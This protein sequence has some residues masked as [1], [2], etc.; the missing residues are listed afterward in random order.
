M[1]S[2]F[3]F[4]VILLVFLFASPIHAFIGFERWYGHPVYVNES[5]W[6]VVQTSDGGYI[7]AGAIGDPTG[8]P[9]PSGECVYLLK[10]DS[11]GDSLWAK[12]CGGEF[13]YS[14]AQTTDDG[15]IITGVTRSPATGS[16]DVY[17]VKT[18]SNG[19][20]MW[21]R[22]YGD[23]NIDCGYSVAQTTDGGYIITGRTF[24]YTTNGYYSDVYLIKTDSSGD[25]LWTR[26]HG[27]R[28]HDG[29]FSVAQ[30][31]DKGYIITGYTRHRSSNVYL[32]KT[33]S[34]GNT[35]WTNTYGN[36]GA[37]IHDEGYSVAQTFDGGYII[38]GYSARDTNNS[39][40][41]IYLLK[42]NSIGN[43][44][45]ERRYGG[46]SDD[47]GRSV[48]QTSDGG[49]IITGITHSWV[50]GGG[51]YLIKTDSS[52][53]TLWTNTYENG[54]YLHSVQQT[55]DG[56]YVA[57]GGRGSSYSWDVYLIKT[58]E[59]GNVGVKET[60]ERKEKREEGE[61]MTVFPNPFSTSTTITLSLP[62][63]GHP[64]GTV[65]TFHGT[66]RTE[67]IE[68]KIFD[69][70]GRLVRTF[71]SSLFSLRSS[72]TWDGKDGSG[73]TVPSGIYFL[74]SLTD[75]HHISEK[76]LKLK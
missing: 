45:W 41:D 46:D 12:T 1:K 3:T 72:V 40:T 44:V 37:D 49:Y 9:W 70:T 71:P 38:T 26:K 14:V 32:I 18:D 56:G 65:D 13:G 48:T 2:F 8:W 20:T 7:V 30:T 50:N 60:E 76:L 55:S 39:I 5:G 23:T 62:S 36:P 29:G 63:I 28:W 51:V 52:G 69:L 34:L 16:K 6:S 27:T 21:S 58:G 25:T 42:T 35:I 61:Q 24:E 33:D 64:D 11:L 19:D 73:K 74:K 4:S 59:N 66:S 57:A 15:Y 10:T 75:E 22:A 67:R 53:D 54:Y 17:L 68:L 47:E 31:T 43:V